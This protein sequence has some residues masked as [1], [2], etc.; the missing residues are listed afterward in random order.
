MLGRQFAALGEAA[1][2]EDVAMRRSHVAFVRTVLSYAV[3]RRIERDGALQLL[4]AVGRKLRRLRLYVVS[5]KEA[6]R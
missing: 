1:A 4:R 3:Y 6:R 5:R 2:G